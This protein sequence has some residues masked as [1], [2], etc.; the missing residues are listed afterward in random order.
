MVLLLPP[1]IY[2]FPGCL[3]CISKNLRTARRLL[4]E[5][6]PIGDEPKRNPCGA[7]GGVRTPDPLLRR[8]ARADSI[9][10][11]YG[12]VAN[13]FYPP[14]RQKVPWPEYL[15]WRSTKIQLNFQG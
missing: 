12:R 11:I 13:L 9:Q 15:V 8:S 5:Y 2:S 4:G 1:S 10:L 3:Y 6:I 14:H 7:P